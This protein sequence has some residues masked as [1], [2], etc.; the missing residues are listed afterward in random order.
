MP[1]RS[2][3]SSC[4]G[5][6]A[7]CER[8]LHPSLPG[9]PGH[10]IARRQM[11]AFGGMVSFTLR[12][13]EQAALEVCT[14]TRVFTL[15]ESL[16][17][18]ESLIEHPGRMTHAAT[19]GSSNEVPGDLVRL[20]VGLEAVDDLVDD[21]D[22]ALDSVGLITSPATGRSRPASG[23]A[24]R[25]SSSDSSAVR[26][27]AALRALLGVAPRS[28]QPGA[29]GVEHDHEGLRAGVEVEPEVRAPLRRGRVGGPR[30]RPSG[31]GG[32][33]SAR[34]RRARCCC[35]IRVTKASTYLIVPAHP[36]KR[37]RAAL[38]F[39]EEWPSVHG[40]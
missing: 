25:T 26:L 18:V 30:P 14:R 19:A 8:V 12:G 4:S 3:S 37:L 33:A 39:R 9:H 32:T 7:P 2:A 15:A 20:S 40:E 23:S 13:G 6:T 28:Q 38:R 24:A 31:S 22:G 27:R 1:T 21:L 17:G 5:P 36:G 29:L 34:C 10:D 35:T 16:G 11:R